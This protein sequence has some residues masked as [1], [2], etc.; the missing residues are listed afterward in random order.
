MELLLTA[1]STF[2]SDDAH[3]T[4]CPAPPQYLNETNCWFLLKERNSVSSGIK[5]SHF[6]IIYT[7][8]IYWSPSVY[9]TEP[10]RRRVWLDFNYFSYNYVNNT[11][12]VMFITFSDCLEDMG[13]IKVFFHG[14]LE[15]GGLIAV[16][17]LIQNYNFIPEILF[18]HQDITHT[19]F[20]WQKQKIPQI[21]VN[22]E[23]WLALP[24]IF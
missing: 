24:V 12:N 1:E 20:W 15:I 8:N 11:T 18:L 6:H 7:R 23:V 9:K 3:T 2:I 14:R 13:P 5:S 4:S 17:F 10:L 16:L 21:Y 22:L 19:R